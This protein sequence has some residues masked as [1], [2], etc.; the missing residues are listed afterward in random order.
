MTERTYQILIKKKQ[1]RSGY[2]FD[3][4]DFRKTKKKTTI[5]K[6]KP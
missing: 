6:E 4:V 2:I 5:D 3:Q 1:S